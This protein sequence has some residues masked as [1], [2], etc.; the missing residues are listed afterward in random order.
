[1]AASTELE[2]P[3]DVL[4]LVGD[5][6]AGNWQPVTEA[7]MAAIL[8]EAEALT[9]DPLTDGQPPTWKWNLGSD[10]ALMRRFLRGDET[11]TLIELTFVVRINLNAHDWHLEH[12]GRDRFIDIRSRFLDVLARLIFDRTPEDWEAV[13]LDR[14]LG[15]RVHLKSGERIRRLREAV[16]WSQGQLAERLGVWRSTVVRWESGDRQPT[17][18]HAAGLARLLGGRPADFLAPDSNDSEEG[19]AGRELP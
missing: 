6:L 7:E 17:F 2:G 18:A 16:G 15:P 4:R 12:L 13:L 11:I 1:M 8:R 10:I 19:L 3:G 5:L 9:M 14:P